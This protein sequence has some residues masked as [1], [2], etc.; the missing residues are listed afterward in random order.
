MA[1][2]DA[3][4][5]AVLD[6]IASYGRP[7]ID[8]LPLDKAREAARVGYL[9]LQG[10]REEVASVV[11][12]EMP[13]PL[14]PIRLRTYRPAG[15]R[16][17][18]ALP[19]LIFIHG[20]GFV[21]MDLE[22]YDGFA[23]RFANLSHCAVVMVDYRLAPESRFPGPVDE[24]VAAVRWISANAARLGLDPARLAVGGDSAGGNLSAVA[25]LALRG[26]MEPPLAYQMLIY[27]A[28]D[29]RGTSPSNSAFGEG[30][31]L[32]AALMKWF[33]GQYIA[34]DSDKLDWRASPLLAPSHAG[35]P[36]ACVI[37]CGFDPLQD[38]GRAYAEKLRAAGVPVT[39]RD[40]A[41]Q[42]HGFML[43]D[44]PLRQA[45]EAVAE[46]AA[47]LKAALSA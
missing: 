37:T 46:T 30:Y 32:T 20:G 21:V 43:M 7:T 15:S 22:C 17:G 23:R 44:K 11:D 36:P 9:M 25:A 18:A 45:N 35:L 3:E 8:L 5:R 28:T 38:E 42:I 19:A 41:T 31:F 33:V 16:D 1:T 13:G 27:P 14:G 4:A 12:C 29:L 40:Y 39:L 2:L 6:L 26:N 10:P 34:R 24:S 47:V